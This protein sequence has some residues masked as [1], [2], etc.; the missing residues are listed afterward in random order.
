MALIEWKEEMSV[1][2]VE[3]DNHHK[4]L[5]AMINE[6]GVAIGENRG[7]DY[8]QHSISELGDYA[9]Y[10]FDLEH[11][12]F[13]KYGYSETDE[14]MA[15]HTSFVEK[16][17]NTANQIRDGRILL[18]INFLYFMKDWLINHIMVVDQRYTSLLLEKGIR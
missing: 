4:K 16:I 15:E 12:Y 2:V 17:Q 13:L 3:L 1:G 9:V 11:K 8:V 14:H 6:L 10:H 7:P 5:L 18:S